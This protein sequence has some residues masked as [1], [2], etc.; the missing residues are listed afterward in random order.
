MFRKAVDE[1]AVSAQAVA[2]EVAA[3]GCFPTL[4]N[5]D[6]VQ[7]GVGAAFVP[8]EKHSVFI[9]VID[10]KMF[11]GHRNRSRHVI[12]LD[13]CGCGREWLPVTPIKNMGKTQR[14]CSQISRDTVPWVPRKGWIEL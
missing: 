2:L 10:P 9:V 5:E 8:V 6:V 3:E 7:A 11:K 13:D 12:G 1:G 14:L 4:A